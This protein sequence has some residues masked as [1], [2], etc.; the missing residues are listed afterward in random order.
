MACTCYEFLTV[1]QA[2]FSLENIPRTSKTVQILTYVKKK[3]KKN[4]SLYNISVFC[5]NTKKLI[6]FSFSLTY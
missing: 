4:K 2:I 1:I 6:Y 3:K 5:T